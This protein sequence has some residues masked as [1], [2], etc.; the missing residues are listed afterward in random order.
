VIRL[1]RESRKSNIYKAIYNLNLNEKKTSTDLPDSLNAL[2]FGQEPHLSGEFI[3]Q[4]SSE[5]LYSLVG[6]HLFQSHLKQ[7]YEDNEMS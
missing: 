3:Q 7:S 6:I 5:N 2:L 4:I 1:A